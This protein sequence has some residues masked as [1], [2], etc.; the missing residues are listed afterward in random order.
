MRTVAFFLLLAAAAAAGPKENLPEDCVVVNSFDFAALRKSEAW[1]RVSKPIAEF[2]NEAMELEGFLEAMKFDPEKDLVSLTVA[3]GGDIAKGEEQVYVVARGTFDAKKFAAALEPSGIKPVER[4]G[5]TVFEDKELQGKRFCGF[6]GAFGVVDG[7]LLFAHP[8][9][10][11]DTLHAA[12]KEGAEPGAIAKMLQAAPEAHAWTVFLPTKA[13]RDELGKEP[14]GAPFAALTSAVLTYKLGAEIEVALKAET[15]SEDLAKQVA[16][17]AQ[18]G[19]MG[20][21][22]KQRAKLECKGATI[23]GSLKVPWDEAR[24]MMGMAAGGA[25]GPEGEDR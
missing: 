4:D 11:L 20:L 16:N 3:L 9:K 15:E 2:L 21:G 6:D 14:E 18:V 23:E 8:A 7:M 1:G 17:V 10:G 25:G 5:M 12:T 24:A 13:L 22:L 19:L